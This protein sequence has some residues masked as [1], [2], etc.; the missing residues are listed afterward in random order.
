M[1]GST[2]KRIAYCECGARL[3]EGSEQELFDAAERHIAR[4]HPHWLPERR[5]SSVSC[6]V[7]EREGV[8]R[9]P[10]GLGAVSRARGD[11]ARFHPTA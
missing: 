10:T 5:A 3:A 11:Q 1:I 2:G 8:S 4:H 7:P 6:L 9:A